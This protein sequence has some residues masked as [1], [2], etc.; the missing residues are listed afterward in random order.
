MHKQVI[1]SGSAM[2]TLVMPNSTIMAADEGRVLFD[3][4]RAAAPG[5]AAA[6]VSSAV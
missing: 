1:V 6:W 4:T 3:F 2:R 5:V